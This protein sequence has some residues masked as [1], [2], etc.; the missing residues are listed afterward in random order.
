MKVG[1]FTLIELMIVIAIIA[2]L[3]SM[4]LPALGNGRNSARKIACLG[5]LRQVGQ[6]MTS[7]LQDY[8]DFI[9][10]Y[11]SGNDQ[12]F[13][14]LNTYIGGQSKRGFNK[15]WICPMAKWQQVLSSNGIA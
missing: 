3:A 12:C 14:E 13:Y 2:I 15:V 9:V 4:L 10:P 1:K 7:Y 8:N 5:N 11:Q 6:G